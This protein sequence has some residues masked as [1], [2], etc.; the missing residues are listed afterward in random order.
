MADD[1]SASMMALAALWT[2]TVLYGLYTCLF[3]ICLYV[4][5]CV[6]PKRNSTSKVNIPLLFSALAMYLLCTAHM[7]IDFHRAILAFTGSSDAK[8]YYSRFWDRANTIR[9]AIYVSN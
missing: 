6:N 8:A 7:A 4:L 5:L 1:L 3:F 2:E 9:Q